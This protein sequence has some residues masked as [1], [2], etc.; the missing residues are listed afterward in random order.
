MQQI[1]LIGDSI[2]RGYEN[3]VHDLLAGRVGMVNPEVNG[4]TS[5]NVLA[6]LDPW[7]MAI[8]PDIVQ[9]NC[10]L[11]DI[12]KPFGE[13]VAAVPLEDYA[14]NVRSI[15]TRL[16]TETDA[17]VIWAAT[18][19]VNQ[20]W[21]NENK[22]FDRFEKDVVAYN[23]VASGIA[24]E[25]DIPI[26]DL[27]AVVSE[28]GRDTLLVDDGVHFTPAGYELLGRAVATYLESVLDRL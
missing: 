13:D 11:H 21:H 18:T 16:K 12:S 20:A 3:F 27:F 6:H 17:I 10:G 28:A 22:S 24:R 25:L 9:V 19:P 7:V 5:A 23:E 8:R 4:G 14:K 15:L 26:N 2:R 1:T